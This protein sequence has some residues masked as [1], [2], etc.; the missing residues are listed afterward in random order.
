MIGEPK[1][2]GTPAADAGPH[3]CRGTV[4]GAGPPQPTTGPARE[5]LIRELGAILAGWGV[6]EGDDDLLAPL[7][8]SVA[9]LL[10]P[11]PEDGA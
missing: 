7:A 9:D 11:G 5:L 1:P 8:Q 10:A 3:A 6:T 2:A 4:T